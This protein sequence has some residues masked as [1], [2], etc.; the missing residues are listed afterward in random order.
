M[1]QTVPH[2]SHKEQISLNSYAQL[3]THL[4]PMLA[5]NFDFLYVRV[6]IS[7][8]ASST[9]CASINTLTGSLE[10]AE[11]AH[12]HRYR[13]ECGPEQ[14]PSCK[15]K[16]YIYLGGSAYDLMGTLRAFHTKASTSQPHRHVGIRRFHIR[17]LKVFSPS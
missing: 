4:V 8:C 12:K 13:V 11:E 17:L 7:C 3:S 9:Y 14:I 6:C 1:R 5:Q 10:D 2:S 16:N 15:E